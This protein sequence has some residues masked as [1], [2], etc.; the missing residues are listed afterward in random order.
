MKHRALEA[1]DPDGVQIIISNSDKDIQITVANVI[2][3]LDQFDFDE[4]LESGGVGLGMVQSLM[5]PEGAELEYK[6]V[7]NYV[8]AILTLRAPVLLNLFESEMNVL[9]AV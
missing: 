5:P 4:S 7:D 1:V 8:R 6:Q 2:E 3:D 9:E